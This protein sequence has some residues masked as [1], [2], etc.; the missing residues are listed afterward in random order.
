[1]TRQIWSMAGSLRRCVISAGDADGRAAAAGRNR[2]FP[3]AGSTAT[4]GVGL[5]RYPR[6]A[7]AVRS[8]RAVRTGYWG[9]WDTVNWL[10]G[11]Q[12]ELGEK[13]KATL[14]GGLATLPETIGV[15]IFVIGVLEAL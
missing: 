15:G 10:T 5:R 9:G 1:M 8:G 13:S 2:G 12:D 6:A 3:H 11:V 14:L 4:P 7:R